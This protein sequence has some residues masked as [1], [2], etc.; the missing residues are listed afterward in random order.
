MAARHWPQFVD[1]VGL[2]PPSDMRFG[3]VSLG[4][5]TKKRQT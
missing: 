1:V 3:S 5:I 2:N 4:A